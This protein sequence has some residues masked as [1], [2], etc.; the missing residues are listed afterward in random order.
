MVSGLLLDDRKKDVTCPPQKVNAA[1]R[2]R[3]E[4]G[5]IADSTESADG[6]QGQQEACEWSGADSEAVAPSRP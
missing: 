4:Y 1:W 6:K 5:E 2:A 3:M